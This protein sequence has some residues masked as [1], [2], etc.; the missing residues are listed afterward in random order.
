MRP[1]PVAGLGFGG[2]R[3]TFGLLV[4]GRLCRVSCFG[5]VICLEDL[6][7]EDSGW[8][9]GARARCQEG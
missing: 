1:V 3:S 8:A 6:G 4:D 5:L 7:E 9:P 2:S